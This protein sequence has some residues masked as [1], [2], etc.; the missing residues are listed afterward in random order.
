MERKGSGYSLT[1]IQVNPVSDRGVGDVGGS[2]ACAYLEGRTDLTFFL[3]RV[4]VRLSVSLERSEQIK[5]F[6]AR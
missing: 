5:N 3:C 4:L 6:F 2:N 1:G